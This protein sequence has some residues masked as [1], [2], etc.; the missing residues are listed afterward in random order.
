[1]QEGTTQGLRGLGPLKAPAGS[2]GEA[3]DRESRSRNPPETE[4]I[5][6]LRNLIS[7][8]YTS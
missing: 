1:M 3:F 7:S 5:F 4:E 2:R 8:N 6:A